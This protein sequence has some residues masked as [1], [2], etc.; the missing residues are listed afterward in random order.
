MA[1][2]A[3]NLF[4][5]I[6]SGK[7]GGSAQLGGHGSEGDDPIASCEWPGEADEI[8]SVAREAYDL[9]S[10]TNRKG[11][12][13]FQTVTLESLGAR[14]FDLLFS[15]DFQEILRHTSAEYLV[16]SLDRT[17]LFIPWE[18]IHDGNDFLCCRFS[19]G[20]I[21]RDSTG[22]RNQPQKGSGGKIPIAI[23]ADPQKNLPVAAEEGDALHR[24]FGSLPDVDLHLLR[25]P[26]SLSEA[27]GCLSG[28][29]IFHFCGHGEIPGEGGFESAWRLSD[30]SISALD[31]LEQGRDRRSLPR[32][33]FSNACHTGVASHENLS[34]LPGS[35]TLSESLAEAFLSSGTS[36]FVGAV[37]D[38]LDESGQEF[39][40]A[41]YPKAIARDSL[42]NA[43]RQ[44]RLE[45][46]SRKNEADL[47][48]A[49]Y[50]LYGD[51]RL[52][53]Y[54]ENTVS[55]E[56]RTLLFAKIS[57]SDSPDGGS[58]PIEWRR[59]REA[60]KTSIGDLLIAYPGAFETPSEDGVLCVVFPNPSSTVRF[61]LE[62]QKRSLSVP[63]SE[64]P[65]E[66]AIPEI[67]ICAGEVYIERL[68]N[69]VINIRG[70][71]YDIARYLSRIAVPGQTLV[72]RAVFDDARAILGSK[73]IEDVGELAWFDH[74]AYRFEGFEEP[75]GV[76]EVGTKRTA[77]LIPPGD[78]EIAR[79][80]VPSDQE[81]VLGWR[82]AL[83]L[84]VPTSPG[85]LLIEKLGEGGFGEVWRAKH[86]H[87]SATRVFKFCFKADRVRSLKREATLFRVLRESVGD[88]RG[89]VRILSTYF[90]EPP[91]YIEMEDVP[92]KNL[93]EWFDL[94]G[95]G[96]LIPLGVRLEIV[97]QTAEALQAAHDAGVIHRDI[98]PSNILVVGNPDNANEIL[99]KLSDF[100]IGQVREKSLLGDVTSSGFTETFSATELSS[101]S[102]TRLYMAPELLVG[103]T[104]S[105][106]ADVYSLGVV[107]YQLLVGDL[108]RPLAS[109][110]R[111]EITE[112]LLIRDLEAC[113]SG[114][115]AKRMGAVGD[116]AVRIRSLEER[117]I[118]RIEEERAEKRKSRNR[119]VAAIS[120]LSVV[121]IFLVT[122][123]LGFGLVRESRARLDAEREAYYST[124]GLAQA[125]IQ[126]GKLGA[127][128]ELLLGLP[129]ELRNWEWGWL[130]RLCNLDHGSYSH[131]TSIAS[132]FD[133]SPDGRLL[134]IG[135]RDGTV[136]LLDI[137]TG[138]V[139]L[140]FSLSMARPTN[141]VFDPTG[142]L[143]AASVGD[144]GIVVYDLETRK[145]V[146]N[147]S[148]P[149]SFFQILRFHPNG[150]LLAAEVIGRDSPV[151]LWNV[152]TQEVAHLL[153]SH[154]SGGLDLQFDRNGDRVAI[155]TH[156]G[157]VRIWDVAAQQ[158][159]LVYRTHGTLACYTAK[160]SP[161]GNY[162]ASGAG[163]EHIRVWNATTG[164]DIAVSPFLAGG[165]EVFFLSDG[166]TVLA[167]DFQ[168]N[169]VVWDWRE[170]RTL[171]SERF[172]HHGWRLDP[173]EKKVWILDDS[174]RIKSI[175]LPIP[176]PAIPL[177][178]PTQFATG[179]E[180]TPDGLRLALAGADNA[181]SVCSATDGREIEF[182]SVY[183]HIHALDLSRDGTKALVGMHGGDLGWSGIVDLTT[184][185]MITEF[186]GQEYSIHCVAFS[187]DEK[188][189]ATGGSGRS[190]YL[191]DAA[192]G[193]RLNVLEGHSDTLTT[194]EWGRDGSRLYSCS[195][196][197]TI[198]VWDPLV[199]SELRTVS[200]H[201]GAVHHLTL[202]PSGK[203]LVSTSADLSAK[204]WDTDSFEEIM[205]LRHSSPVMFA[206]F[207]PDGQ[208]IFTYSEHQTLN[209]WDAGTGKQILSPVGTER[210]AFSPDGKTLAAFGN[211][212]HCLLFQ[213]FPWKESDYPGSDSDPFLERLERYKRDYWKQ[214]PP[215][216]IES[217][218]PK[219]APPAPPV[220]GYW[221]FENGDLEAHVGRALEYFNDYPS[222]IESES[223][224]RFGT[225]SQLNIPLIDEVDKKVLAFA[226]FDMDCGYRL[227]SGC[228]AN[229]G[230]NEVNWYTL[231][232]DLFLPEATR[233]QLIP[234]YNTNP[235][236]RNVPELEISGDGGIGM[237]GNYL[238]EF[239]RGVWNRLVCSVDV[240]TTSQPTLTTYLNGELVG[241]HN[242]SSTIDGRWAC[243][244][245]SR[246][247]PLLL[248]AGWEE[249]GV[250]GYVSAVQFR[251]Y[252]M[253]AEEVRALGGPS[254]EGIPV[255]TQPALP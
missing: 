69:N 168:G 85:W 163:N 213:A 52:G 119:F 30:G 35:S 221:D 152:D 110:W 60:L 135:A 40:N 189:V 51:P 12:G 206:Q 149:A 4:L 154:E 17:S 248:F 140:S 26:V 172:R 251:N 183:D 105:T 156:G 178:G 181:L 67:G 131:P 31:I 241:I 239:P 99:V 114:E 118:E 130:L 48:W 225:C 76:G 62:L 78:S 57:N 235:N 125:M 68:E 87:S 203:R 171:F 49:Q 5:E 242:L 61:A 43:I 25:G 42:G 151:A 93:S 116:L 222:Q 208:R 6:R 91:F 244:P 54:G 58:N 111:E 226:D 209:I 141:V 132:H 196:D 103:K 73:E 145:E 162:V 23:V 95:G 179:C 10:S 123:A 47:V 247:L 82:P 3:A 100:G 56:S 109:D 37:S 220:T 254:A 121:V 133:I 224:T 207:T 46:R 90:E 237:D 41:F 160:F 231:I 153:G 232:M 44:A 186:L 89:I 234:I 94:Y 187:P 144:K 75:L 38:L 24:L 14:L 240:T 96:E 201:R 22:G 27:Q 115:P 104:S 159:T 11:Q 245:G 143:L 106:R 86:K 169:I 165:Y 16:L 199:G 223:K 129:E 217:L 126:E 88:H 188:T 250:S 150:K 167:T 74:G 80:F 2:G 70:R 45:V 243:Y 98:K 148:D 122:L 195:D 158:E 219:P 139:L 79:R 229:S 182:S 128:E 113:L 28:F 137:E 1:V 50:V 127:A 236:N 194:L 249:G 215:A 112:P 216:G 15:P 55:V 138:D 192:T 253:T 197:Q 36:H 108:T 65:S 214:F 146:S 13:A 7:S 19:M 255:E 120:S 29:D 191:W 198:R 84:E 97:A 170:N 185:K 39:A 71:P 205:T 246:A 227:F 20:R 124:V 101:A 177:R 66:S 210:F 9:I 175:P 147:L 134:A 81:P 59:R 190:I 32:L 176:K 180:F 202:D 157:S 53:L 230:G 21:L 164:A 166:N 142:K 107:L 77:P 72:S 34:S 218:R 64:S 228:P 200:A 184:G 83:D 252:P 174:Y 33:V 155:A 63:Q 92:G 102:G 8:W 204:V 193:L 211:E 233:G 212:I 117:R 136:A 238:G 161:D 173:S 18:L